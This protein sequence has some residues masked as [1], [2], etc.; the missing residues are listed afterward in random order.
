[1]S[2]NAKPYK[3][4]LNLPVTRFDM[5][6][7]LTTRE[8]KIQ[9]RW[10]DANLYAQI[11]N[12]RE[13]RERRVLHD[14]PPYANGEIHMGHLLNKV[15]KD[16][17][18]RSFNM[19]GFDS[20]YVPGWDC[21][22][23]PIEHKVM[24]DLGSKGASKTH[25]EIRSLCQAEA[26]KWVDVQRQQFKRLGV[27]GD[28][29]NPYLTLDPRYEAGIL[30]VLGDL[31]ERGYVF[32]QLK[33]IHWCMTDRTALA[34]AE[35]EYHDETSSSIYVNFP[36]V[37]GLPES[38]G[39]GPWHVMI[40]TTT[41]WT[42]PANVAIA[43]HPSLT[44]VGIEYL[45][46]TSG[47]PVHTVLAA[48]LVAKV[49]A[50]REVTQFREVGRCTGKELEHVQYKHPFIERMS[51]IVLA[52]YVTIEDGTGLVHTAP[53]H[54]T[55]D[56]QTG[57]NYG[58]PTLSPVDASGRFTSEAPEFLV[59]KGVFAANP[60][61]VTLLRESGHLFHHLNFLHSYPHC[62]RCKKPVIFRAT[63]QWFIAV[64]H[65]NLR[66]ET[67][68]QIDAVRWLPGWGKS[69]IDAMV[70]LRP[71]WCISRQ[72]AWGVPIPAL[73]CKACGSQLLTAETVRHFRDL[74]RQEGADAWYT[75]PV[76][77][78]LPPGATCPKCGG[79]DFQKEGDIL[80]VWFESGSSHRG[81]L[82]Q[83]FEL[84]Y[85]AYMY[86]EG[87]DQHRGWFQSSILTAV[88][89]TGR[90]P[91]ENVLTH[92]FVVTAEG[93][94]M[95]KSGG[96]AISAVKSSEQYGADVLRLYVA[97]MDYADDVRMSERGI[98]E[99]SESYRKIRNTFR[100]LLGNLEDYAHPEFLE[101][102]RDA[103]HEI[104]RWA[105]QQLNRLIVD[106][107]KAYQEFEFYRVYQRIYQFCSVDLSSF[108]LD[109]LKDRLYAEAPKGNDRK[110]AQFVM[111]KL[112][113]VL[114]RLLAPL[115]PHTAEEIWDFTPPSAEKLESV[116]LT[117]WPAPEPEWDTGDGR[118]KL[119][120]DAILDYRAEILKGLE[121]LRAAKIIG[122]SQEALVTL[123]SDDPQESELLK[124][125]RST[126]ETVCIVS[127]IRLESE[128]PAEATTL[129]ERPKSWVYA[130]RSSHAKCERCW[131]LRPTVGQSVDHPTLCERCTQ[132]VSSLPG[133]AGASQ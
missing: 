2:T 78:I 29:E 68:K 75:K 43:A 127:E 89:T 56:Y 91:F 128:R 72:R 33:P 99:M 118:P 32:R 22:G 61:I 12:A 77:E 80:D 93:A 106:V 1:M 31:L 124:S 62:W 46:P 42:L 132:V 133:F 50:M 115:I 63:E 71:D 28:W 59:G 113:S 90:A 26:L 100:Y 121:K 9:Q 40:W 30:D 96:N 18:V 103:L 13:G 27:G 8:P 58:L 95:S 110:A 55:E 97:S 70:S 4:T 53:G 81:V 131:N 73:G 102:P 25:A 48:E 87:S 122:S 109:V 20:P 14:G 88:G 105:L 64:D 7:N 49:M 15:L 45:D 107:V 84:G 65:D 11:R 126:L 44:Y 120:W 39:A 6:A 3:D 57:R 24:K 83:G 123:G 5:K 41:P 52:E 130:V 82:A 117:E 92:G 47:Q 94:K 54:G 23:L 36:V 129:V 19:Q 35:L 104:D 60:E 17:V 10:Q 116:H 86:L 76:E 51:P 98:K 38:W 101:I 69:R 119:P 74:F 37:S 16:I 108:Y 34:E 125:L 66:A 21:H 114:T 111:A 112:H 85:P 79:K 67:L